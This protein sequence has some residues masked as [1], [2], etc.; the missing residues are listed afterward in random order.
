MCNMERALCSVSNKDAADVTHGQVIGELKLHCKI[1]DLRISFNKR[2]N[3]KVDSFEKSMDKI[4]RAR[5]CL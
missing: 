1:D 3:C 2:L 4:M 5:C